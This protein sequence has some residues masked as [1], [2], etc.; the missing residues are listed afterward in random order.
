M[1][2]PTSYSVDEHGQ[3]RTVRG[4]KL[5]RKADLR[6]VYDNKKTKTLNGATKASLTKLKDGSIGFKTRVASGERR[7]KQLAK[8]AASTKIAAAVRGKQARKS[9]AGKKSP[10]RAASPAPTRRSSRLKK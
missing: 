1:T 7:V 9:L 8:A 2:K 3:K 4:R 10:K 6:A 5:A